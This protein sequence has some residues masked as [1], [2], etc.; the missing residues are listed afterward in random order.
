MRNLKVLTVVALLAV[1]PLSI[2][3]DGWIKSYGEAGIDWGY[4]VQQT[5]DGGYIVAGR[6]NYEYAGYS[7]SQEVAGGVWLLKFDSYGDTLWTKLYGA[8]GDEGYWVQQTSDKGYIIVGWTKSQATSG[9]RDLWLLKTDPFGDTLWTRVYGYSPKHSQGLDYD[10]GY[11]VLQTSDGGYIVAGRRNSPPSPFS[12]STTSLWILKTDETGDTLW[13]RYYDQEESNEAASIQ[14]TSDG[15]YIVTGYSHDTD[16][17]VIL[18]KIDS[19]GDSLWLRTYGDQNSGNSVKQTPDGG[20]IVAGTVITTSEPGWAHQACWLLKTDDEGDSIWARNYTYDDW[21]IATSVELTDDGGLVLVGITGGELPADP[22]SILLFKTDESGDTLWTR[23]FRED[24]TLCDA[25][26]S[27]QQTTD[28]GYVITGCVDGLNTPFFLEADVVLIKTDSLGNLT[29]I[30]EQPKAVEN[31]RN[32]KVLKSVGSQITL[33]YSNQPHGFHADIFDAAGRMV[34][35]LVSPV[36]AGTITWG[37]GRPCG[38]Y[39]INVSDTRV[40]VVRRVVI[41]H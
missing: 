30:S 34:D 31:P 8:S 12:T 39:F 29:A 6:K 21:N 5:T 4:C 36:P 32:W 16:P 13:T 40:N 27:V 7:Q 24:D 23:V 19:L 38:V 10:V 11:S 20:Y 25:G 17:H 28:R 1:I 33:E 14:E 9:T 41:V 2:Y 15:G 37:E 3:A 35:V 26:F 18:I 22:T